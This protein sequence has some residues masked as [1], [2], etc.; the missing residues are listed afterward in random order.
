M[1]EKK[2]TPKKSA[3]EKK[4]KKPA[5]KK[6]AISK[7]KKALLGDLAK[8]AESLEEESIKFLIAQGQVML[9]NK[10]IQEIRAERKERKP[11]EPIEGKIGP[12]RKFKGSDKE[13]ID[14]VESA[15]GSSFVLLINNYRNFFDR[16]EMRKLV[17]ICHSADD[18]RDAMS[19]LHG[20]FSKNRKDV[21]TNTDIRSAGDK[22]LATMYNAIITTYAV[23]E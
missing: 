11:A 2:S 8:I 23:K 17:K 7:E 22:A 6:T 3:A 10:K 20:W 16:D 13:S 5:P 19:R 9:Q 15:S 1:A 18:E 4:P 12:G 21:L 14:I